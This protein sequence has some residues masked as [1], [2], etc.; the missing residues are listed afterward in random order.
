[1]VSEQFEWSLQALAQPASTQIGLFPEY[2]NAADELALSWEEA[3]EDAE[4]AE[5]PVAPQKVIKEL[6]DYMLSISGK[7]NSDLWTNYSITN[8]VQWA[9]MRKLAGEAI[10]ELGWEKATPRK[11]SW[12]IYVQDGDNQT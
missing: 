9:R 4:L 6:D 8:S 11:P 12:A 5:L 7:D 3:L 1:M 10:L 2:A